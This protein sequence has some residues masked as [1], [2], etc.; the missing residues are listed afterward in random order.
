MKR[1]EA[2]SRLKQHEADLKRR[3]VEHLYMFG[4]TARGK[5]QGDSDFDL[6][7][8]H[9]KGKLGVYELMDVKVYA[10]SI[11]GRKTAIMTRDSLY[12]TLRG[13]LKKQPCACF[14]DRSFPHSTSDGH[15]RGHRTDSCRVRGYA[16]RCARG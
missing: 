11:L 9:E 2:I 7:F 1:D 3:G 15:Y 5:A 6:F 8:D 13:K 16:S 4:S 10:A 12:K 14:S